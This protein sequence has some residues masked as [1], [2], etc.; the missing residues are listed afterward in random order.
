MFTT[1]HQNKPTIECALIESYKLVGLKPPKEIVWVKSPEAG[2]KL[3]STF[4]GNWV[5]PWFDRFYG[6][7]WRL[8]SMSQRKQLYDYDVYNGRIVDGRYI[9]RN[10][11]F[12]QLRDQYGKLA[13]R[14]VGRGVSSH[15]TAVQLGGRFEPL[16]TLAQ[17]QHISWFYPKT[18]I[19]CENPIVVKLDEQNRFHS[20]TSL[21][22]EY[23]DG[24]GI[25]AVHGTN[26]P[27]RWV[28]APEKKPANPTRF[29]WPP[30]QPRNA[31]KWRNMEQRRAAVEIYG[32][33]K[34]LRKL[35]A[36]VINEDPDPE[37]G[38]LFEITIPTNYPTSTRSQQA[39]FLRV[40]CGTG[41][42]FVVNVPRF[43]QTALEAQQQCWNVKTYAP[44]VRT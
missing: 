32:W 6:V 10:D 2:F 43:C 5:Q 9:D 25:A 13:V 21:A 29:N 23:P 40:R 14:H 27:A 7:W 35:A 19:L 15:F 20:T 11:V 4:T 1:G 33:E 36:T 17:N 44:E 26:V 28:T 39:R 18:T 12:D 37:I 8:L 38:T 41:R 24:W 42:T 31:L 34:L 16:S 22:V 30:L 3:A